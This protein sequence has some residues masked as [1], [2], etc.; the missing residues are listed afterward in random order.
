[1]SAKR[2]AEREER[3]RSPTT[4]AET[5]RGTRGA[6]RGKG[7]AAAAGATATEGVLVEMN[8]EGND[9]GE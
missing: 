9:D 4:T 6:A 2:A 1:M 3:L 8:A 7:R 5:A